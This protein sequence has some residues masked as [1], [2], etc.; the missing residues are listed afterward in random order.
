[1]AEVA[2]VVQSAALII[3]QYPQSYGYIGG[4]EKLTRQNN[5]RLYLIVFDKCFAYGLGII[6]AQ[7]TIS[8]EEPGNPFV[9][10][11]FREHVENPRVVGVAFGRCAV[12]GPV[13]ALCYVGL[14]PVFKVERRI[15]HDVIKGQS[16]V[17][18]FLEC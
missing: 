8:E 15:G 18:V 13:H 17:M 9:G 10:F 4:V 11:N 14:E 1:M 6:I 5:N 3:V 16:G 7:S 2:P 12:V